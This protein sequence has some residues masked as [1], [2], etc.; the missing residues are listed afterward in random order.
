MNTDSVLQ[1]AERLQTL[2][3]FS[4]SDCDESA[5]FEPQLRSRSPNSQ[6]AC[7]LGSSIELFDRS[8]SSSTAL[9]ASLRTDQNSG[10]NFG[11]DSGSDS[12]EFSD[13]EVQRLSGGGLS[14]KLRSGGL[15]N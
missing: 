2:D 6:L 15:A 4:E 9:L 1:N 12:G 14:S 10:P 11:S 3:S 8:M 13:S 7:S 5:N